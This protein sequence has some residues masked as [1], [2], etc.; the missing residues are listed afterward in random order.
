[1][2]AVRVLSLRTDRRITQEELASRA[3]LHPRY[4]SAIESA[5]QVPSLTSIAQLANGLGVGLAELVSIDA[6]EKSTAGKMDA[7]VEAIARRLRKSD[8]AT[9]RKIRKIVEVLTEK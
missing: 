1:R 2:F 4:I 8:L 5:R 3:G 6:F 7:E 9:V